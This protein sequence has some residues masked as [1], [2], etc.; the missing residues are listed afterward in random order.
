[1]TGWER[2]ERGAVTD[3]PLEWLRSLDSPLTPLGGT[4]I[5]CQLPV[6]IQ[7]SKCMAHRN[8]EYHPARC[9][10]GYTARC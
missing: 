10:A 9:A 2:G 1:M 4:N 6:L 3:D 7:I 5:S 8:S